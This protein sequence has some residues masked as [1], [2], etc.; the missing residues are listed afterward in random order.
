MKKIPGMRPLLLLFI[1]S[2]ILSAGCK[3]NDN[4]AGPG[5]GKDLDFTFSD[6]LEI[7]LPIKFIS[8]ASPSSVFLWQFGT[9]DQ[10][11]ADSPSYTYSIAGAF[12]VTLKVNDT[13]AG[14]TKTVYVSIGTDRLEKIIATRAWSGTIKTH[15]ASLDTTYNFTDSN[16][17]CCTIATDTSLFAYS[18][19][20][21]YMRPFSNSPFNKTVSFGVGDVNNPNTDWSL[22]YYN[23]QKDS[24]DLTIY[25]G[26]SSS[27]IKYDF[28]SIH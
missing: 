8:N 3:K 1:V 17:T 22:L 19:E 11:T 5:F 6:S 25:S 2:S 24:I 21:K 23:Y 10:S 26:N 16:F 28:Q 18:N 20:F 27:Y 4:A 7:G 15:N 13:G 14:V 12:Q 9:G